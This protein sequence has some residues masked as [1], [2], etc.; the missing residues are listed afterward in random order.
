MSDRTYAPDIESKSFPPAGPDEPSLELLLA[1]PRPDDD[2]RPPCG[3]ALFPEIPTWTDDQLI[4]AIELAG[5]ADGVLLDGLGR[6]SFTLVI[7]LG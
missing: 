5:A 2:P 6:V 1:L 4:V 3:A 7:C